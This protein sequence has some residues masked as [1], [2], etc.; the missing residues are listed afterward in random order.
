M[1]RQL[2]VE[3]EELVPVGLDGGRSVV[4]VLPPAPGGP[5]R[6]VVLRL[7]MPL[8]RPVVR[9]R[10]LHEAADGAVTGVE[11]TPVVRVGRQ[12]VLEFPVEPVD[13]GGSARFELDWQ[14]RRRAGE[15]EVPGDQQLMTR[16]LLVAPD[17]DHGD[18]VLASGMLKLLWCDPLGPETAGLLLLRAADGGAV[19]EPAG[20]ALREL[21]AVNREPWPA[22][23]YCV[24]HWELRLLEAAD[25]AWDAAEGC[26]S[27]RLTEALAALDTT[28]EGRTHR[29]PCD[30]RRQNPGARGLPPEIPEDELRRDL[31][32]ARA[33]RLARR[34]GLGTG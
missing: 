24:L 15:R 17:P 6:A 23:P 34:A 18:E 26:G 20:D 19:P 14:V 30:C 4:E 16:V 22:C 10:L 21:V 25:R 28:T 13:G 31:A 5:A 2:V 7:V 29:R 27:T 33:R 3:H 9:T 11:L 32:A 12:C 1:D 8:G